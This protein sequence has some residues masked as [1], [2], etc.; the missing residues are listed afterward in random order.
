M[1]E[2]ELYPLVK[3]ANWT[4]NVIYTTCIAILCRDF[5]FWWLRTSRSLFKRHLGFMLIIILLKKTLA[6][7]DKLYAHFWPADGLIDLISMWLC[8]EQ[9]VK[10]IPLVICSV[11]SSVSDDLYQDFDMLSTTDLHLSFA[12]LWRNVPG[13]S[14]TSLQIWCKIEDNIFTCLHAQ[15]YT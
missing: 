7:R 13:Q 11:L 9:I 5:L 3:R 12:C 8:L 6:A 10:S 2:N 15:L 4:C 1:N 14:T